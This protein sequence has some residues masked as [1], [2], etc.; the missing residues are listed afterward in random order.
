M[1]LPKVIFGTSG[2]G[3]LYT[4][5]PKQVKCAII[6]E[7]IKTNCEGNKPFFDSAG[8]Y[9]AGLALESLGYCLSHLKVAR[10]DVV[11]SN[12]LGWLRT[13]LTTAEPT[14]EPG[15]W[16]S[17]KHDAIQKISYDGILECYEQ[18][19]Q[20]L[21]GYK[22]AYVSVHDP[23]E[24]LAAASDVRDEEL[25]YRNILAAYQALKG[26]KQQGKVEAI[27]VGAKDWKS[28]AR[29]DQD[30]CLDWVMI[31]NS[32][33]VY[34]HRS[35]LLTFLAKLKKQGTVIINSALFNGGF[36]TGG[37]YYNYQS[38]D[39][40]SESGRKLLNWRTQFFG[41]CKEFGVAPAAVCI[42][43]GMSAPGV[44]SVALS[45]TEPGQVAS[46]AELLHVAVPDS[47]WTRLYNLG[48]ISK[49]GADM[50][51]NKE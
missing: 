45:S 47:L 46:N 42:R 50:I 20:L 24:Y 12:K 40:E 3:N 38:V 17:L 11:I 22:A 14:F 21:G 10:E 33:T 43:F 6:E 25:R 16:K 7:Y 26:L 18:G 13:T 4:I 1:N 31:A 37:G 41:V 36:L 28:I 23:D 27:G 44:Q 19:N 51:L 48:L 49:D 5:L 9:G 39:P 15:V 8:K 2:L 35:E 32:M 34:S 30:I 29:I